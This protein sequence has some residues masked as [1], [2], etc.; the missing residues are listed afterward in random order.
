MLN[1]WPLF[2]K[3]YSA[4][5]AGF[6]DL[7]N[8]TGT[9]FAELLENGYESVIAAVPQWTA[10]S[11][12]V[13]ILGKKYTLDPSLEHEAIG[14]ITNYVQNMSL[15]DGIVTTQFTWLNTFDVNTKFLLI[16]RI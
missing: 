16:V 4:F 3:R 13:E 11:L 15:S 6:Y 2:N 14:D 1:G 10:L 8:T 7:Q 9:N 5:V 12:S